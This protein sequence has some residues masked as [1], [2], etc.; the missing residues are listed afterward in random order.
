[1]EKTGKRPFVKRN[2]KKT[3][4]KTQKRS[5]KFSFAHMSSIAKWGFEDRY[6]TQ[7]TYS[8]KFSLS[9]GN[10]CAQYTYRGNSAYDPDWT[11]TGHQPFYFKEFVPVYQRYRV[12]ASKVEVSVMN[13]A[14][15][16]PV[17][18]TVVPHS[19]LIV[20][21][22][23]SDPMEY[24]HSKAAKLLGVGGMLTSHVKH[25]IST[26]AL[27][28]LYRK[29]V[30]DLDYSSLVSTNPVSIWY[31]HLVF[32]S[33]QQDVTVALQIKIVYDIEFYDKVASTPS[34][35]VIKDPESCPKEF[36]QQLSGRISD[37]VGPVTQV[38]IR[39]QPVAVSISAL[40]TFEA[41]PKN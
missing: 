41:G 14:G 19:E 40:R 38:V 26:P 39:E 1:M 15:T 11:G 22:Y 13:N 16:T 30:L 12:M 36:R 9:P 8:D 21:T 4:K 18:L 2:G 6:V 23:A 20:F 10:H 17:Q 29:E 25:K 37:P 33:C 5:P 35:N 24:P 32:Q 3:N 34:M 7:L 27:L 31:W 28:G